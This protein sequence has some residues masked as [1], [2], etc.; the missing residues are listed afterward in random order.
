MDQRLWML[1]RLAKSP[2]AKTKVARKAAKER[3]VVGFL[4]AITAAS[5]VA[6]AS[7]AKAR[8]ARARKARASMVVV[9][10][11]KAATSITTHAM[12]VDNKD[13]GQMNAPTR[14]R[15]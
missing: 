6:R 8:K 13:I 3:K 12:F 10:E 15:P 14:L 7:K 11:A 1:I 5:M 9:A 4:L 2:S